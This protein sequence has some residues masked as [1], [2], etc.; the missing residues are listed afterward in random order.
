MSGSTTTPT[1]A[2]S[3]G[4]AYAAENWVPSAEVRV[5][6]PRSATSPLRGGAGGRLSWSWHMA[7]VLPPGSVGRLL[8][9]LRYAAEHLR[10]DLPAGVG[11]PL[12][13]PVGLA[14]EPVQLGLVQPR[15]DLGDLAQGLEAAALAPH[16]RGQEL[17]L[18]QVRQRRAV[19][20]PAVELGAGE[21]LAQPQ[22]R[23]LVAA[24]GETERPDLRLQG[25]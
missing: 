11:Q 22:R 3:A 15:L 21:L 2:S 7:S 24:H 23:L 5:S 12:V 14:D 1:R 8:R 17:E 13:L 16:C 9:G 4:A 25:P 20:Q 18:D 10:R 6:V 19:Q